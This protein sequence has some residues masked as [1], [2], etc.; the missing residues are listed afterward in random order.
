M[1]PWALLGG[2]LLAGA[3]LGGAYWQGRADGANA[4]IATQARED[5]AAQTA[6]EAAMQGAADAIRQAAAENTKIVTRIKTVTRDVPVYRDPV[7][8]HDDRVLD[9]LNRQL[10]GTSA[11]DGSLPGGPGGA[12]GPA[13]R[14]DD[15]QA[16]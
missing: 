10:R 14:D 6:R 4:E 15:G 12:A 11:G 5:Q 8:R 7:C 16:R 3:A 1:S 13:V 9:D 2:V